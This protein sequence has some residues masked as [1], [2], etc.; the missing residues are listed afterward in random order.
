VKVV[1]GAVMFQIQHGR[2]LGISKVWYNL[3]N[4]L[5]C[6]LPE[7]SVV[8]LRRK[9]FPTGITGLPEYEIPVYKRDPPSTMD[10]DDAMLTRVCKELEADIFVSTYYTRAP[11][12]CN[13]LMIHDLIPEVLGFDLSQSQWVSKQRAVANADSFIAVS[14]N[15]KADLMRTYKIPPERITVAHNGVSG[16]FRPAEEHQIQL[17]KQ[18]YNIRLPYFLLVGNRSSYKNCIPFFNAFLTL[19]Q[20]R[21]FQIFAFGDLHGIL[22]EETAF[23]QNCNFTCVK[24]LPDS[25]I[26]AAYSGAASLVFPSRYE[27]FGLP[28]LEAMACGCPVI[29]SNRS[30]LPEVGGDA[31]LYVDPDS[32]EEIAQALQKVMDQNVRTVM[33]EKGFGQARKFSWKKMAE[34]TAE[35]FTETFKNVSKPKPDQPSIA[36]GSNPDCSP[37]SQPPS[38]VDKSQPKFDVSI[39]L[40]TKDRAQL[41]DQMLASLKDAV[42][43]ARCE[44]IVVE[45][46]S[47]D[48]TLDVLRAHG[49]KNVYSELQCLG[50]GRHS[51]PQLYNFGF[52][53]AC[54]KWAMYASDDILFSKGCVSRAVELLNR[55]KGEV[56]SGI[57]FYKNTRTRPDWDKFGIDFTL[58]QKL[59]MNYGL[60]RLDYFRAVGGLDEAYRFY[61]ADGD[62]C[63]K[64]YERGKQFIPLPG[65]FVVHNNVLDA[66]KQ[67]NA[68]NSNRDIELYI[69]RWK[70]FVSAQRPNPRR[71]LWQDDFAEAFNLPAGLKKV[72]SGIEHFWHGLACFQYGM[73]EEAKL[74]FLQTLQSA[75]DHWLVLW[76][77]AKAAN[78]CGDKALAEKAAS[79]VLQFV[80]DF[81]QAKDLLG[82]LGSNFEQARRPA[83]SRMRNIGDGTTVNDGVWK[84]LK[85]H[86]DGPVFDDVGFD[87]SDCQTNGEFALLRCLIKPGDVVFDI[88]A[89]TGQWSRQVLSSIGPVKMHSFEPIGDVFAKLETNLRGAGVSLHNIA[90]SDK[91]EVKTFFYYNKSPKLARLSTFYRRCESIE[92]DLNIKPVEIPV[93]A[94][95]LDWFCSEHS[96]SHIDYLKVDTEGAELDVLRGAAGILRGHRVGK[97]QFE[98]GGNYSDAGITLRQICELLTSY[99]YSI[100]RI[101]PQGLVHICRWRDALENYQYSNYA[102]VCPELAGKYKTMEGIAV[103]NVV[104]GSV[105]ANLKDD[106]EKLSNAQAPSAITN[107]DTKSN[108][109]GLIFSKDRPMQ[110]AATI[111]SFLLHRAD[112]S[113]IKLCV[114]FKASNELYRRQYDGLKDEFA[115]VTF[116]EETSF[117]EQTLAVISGYEHV[118]FLVDDNLFV[119]DFHLADVITTLRQNTD[120]I[121]FSLRLGPNTVYS[122]ARDTELNPPAFQSLGRGILKYDWTQGEIHFAYPLE[123]SSSIY[124]TADI[125]PLLK[126]LDFDNPN[127][128][129]GLMAANAQLYTQNKPTLLCYEQ[130]VTFCNPVNIVQTVCNNR[131]GG[132]QRY[133]TDKLAEMFEEG[134]RINVRQY[135]DLVSNSCHQEVELKFHKADSSA[136]VDEPLVSVEMITYNTE[137]FI[138]R[139]I[140]SVLAQ[141]YKNFELLIVDDGSTDRTKEIID[142]YSDSR[143]RYIYKSHKNRWSGTNVAIAQ[144]KGQY[145]ISVD[146]DDFMAADYIEKMVVCAQKHPQID[147]F[148]PDN[149][150]LVDEVGKPAGDRWEYLDFSDN[151]VLPNFL[152]EHA[153]SPIPHPGSLKRKSLYGRVGGYEELQNAADF[154]FLCRNALKIS[155][156]RLQEHSAYFYRLTPSSLSHK[157]RARNQITADVLNDMVSIYPPEVLCPQIARITEPVLRQQQYYKYL[158]E[159]FYKHVNGHMVQY[160]GYFRRYG[161][162]YKQQLLNCATRVNKAASS[163]GG[164]SEDE[165]LLALFKRGVEHLKADRPAQALTCFD[166]IC[167]CSGSR[168]VPDLQYAQAV[169]LARLGRMDEARKACRAQLAAQ[170]DHE[171]ARIFLEKLSERAKIIN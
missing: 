137:K 10:A 78:E 27:G 43:T 120:A 77:L 8:I 38:T 124:R 80:P 146:S 152:F 81:A 55:Q 19:P 3:L 161:D 96:I 166:E 141:T 101:I 94:R 20:H 67:A 170:N 153:Y 64:L 104:E 79:A 39:I 159:T 9:G 165:K 87:N 74:K 47:S 162:Y 46:G 157:F 72:D 123:V 142:S 57:F 84:N 158:M 70:H 116:I 93:Q 149:L 169:A 125:L 71:L 99:G 121:G 53:R 23:S 105:A 171:S 18:K 41:L 154:V 1:I 160:G 135:S 26:A 59:L 34:K 42:G 31:A 48:N 22:P 128:L 62:L 4:E 68:D 11:G 151:K 66:A 147:Y 7:H 15:T 5:K 115:D 12:I 44:L 13:V 102:A 164:L 86:N 150:V 33:I 76:Y 21:N 98:Y 133:S 35:V 106:A 95:T 118:L 97:M 65:C 134:F 88:G 58:G 40:C 83:N 136:A 90:F 25:E 144:A 156:K 60:V 63:F 28:V 82:L 91:N 163:A 119:A 24:W 75:C 16:D 132:D 108:M 61:C 56:A 126:R 122:Y 14:N 85:V 143:I 2:L 111:E 50:P 117:K 113:N 52:S 167:R 36:I 168:N 30:S 114:L 127:I 100:F 112:S 138:V 32:P 139:A 155:F 45:G 109:V 54:G 49:I 148:Y 131:A 103:G 69:Q 6:V 140:D 89:N 107:S 17:F 73:F 145:I 37:A 92:H 129:E 110:L 51:W 29:T 130:S